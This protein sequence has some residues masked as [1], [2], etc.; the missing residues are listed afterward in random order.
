MFLPGFMLFLLFHYVPMYGLLIAFKDYKLTKGIL[1]SPWVGIDN[2]RFMF[3][4]HGLTNALRN[5]V[6]ISLLKYVFVF[7]A[8]IALAILLNEVR[9]VAFRRV[10]QTVSYLPHFFSWVIL[11]GILF[12]FLSR[13]GGFN[14]LLGLIGI[15]PIDWLIDPEKFYGVI[16]LSDIWHS[17]GWGSI[18]Y[19]AALAAIDP[20]LYEAA[21]ADGASRWRRIWHIT[22]P[23]ITPVITTMLLLSIGHFL[24]VGFDQI[25]NLTT[26]TTSSIGDILDTYVLRRLL[27]MDYQLGVAASIFSSVF[28]LLLV[29][30]ANRLVKWYNEDQGLW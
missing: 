23:S 12:T 6:V 11:S 24:S 1:G 14:Q 7:P 3:S 27:S 29:I 25:Y 22:L 16:I 30:A 13:A 18:V 9:L 17:I 2:F 26:P 10:V 20:T 19:F 4:G 8:P 28:G 5:T 15:G 21:I